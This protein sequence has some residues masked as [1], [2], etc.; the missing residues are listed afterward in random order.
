MHFVWIT[1]WWKIFGI[2]SVWWL[3]HTDWLRAVANHQIVFLIQYVDIIYS[4]FDLLITIRGTRWLLCCEAKITR[5]ELVENNYTKSRKKPN[6]LRT[7][8]VGKKSKSVQLPN[9]EDGL[10]QEDS[11]KH[12]E[13]QQCFLLKNGESCQKTAK[14]FFIV[15]AQVVGKRGEGEGGSKWS[16]RSSQSLFS[17]HFLL[18]K[19]F[20]YNINGGSGSV[21]NGVMGSGLRW[22]ASASVWS[23]LG[24]SPSFPSLAELWKR[25]FNCSALRISDQLPKI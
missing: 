23:S 16:K 9:L 22:N 4:I 25:R 19:S 1:F 2:C 15:F 5:R 6:G 13:T 12:E 14:A 21:S 3:H 24:A 7:F 17:P 11:F 10:F 8:F 18:L 20:I